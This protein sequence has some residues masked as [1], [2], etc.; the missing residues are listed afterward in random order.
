MAMLREK[1][2]AITNV[3]AEPMVDVEIVDFTLV[4]P[5]LVVHPYCH[6]EITGRCISI[7]TG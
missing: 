2:A 6:N 5:V 4:A 1:I 7:A 3:L